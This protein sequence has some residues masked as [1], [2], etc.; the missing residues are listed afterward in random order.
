MASLNPQRQ[1]ALCSFERT[2]PRLEL[3]YNEINPLGL[4]TARSFLNGVSVWTRP[5]HILVEGHTLNRKTDGEVGKYLVGR[6]GLGI[7]WCLANV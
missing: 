4:L 2:A 1:L 5:Q 7:E 3:T 6:W